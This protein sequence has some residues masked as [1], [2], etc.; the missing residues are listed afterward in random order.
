VDPVTG[1]S[2]TQQIAIGL[3][4]PLGI[5]GSTVATLVDERGDDTCPDQAYECA[6]LESGEPIVIGVIDASAPSTAWPLADLR[7]ESFP[8]IQGH[9]IQ[10]DV[11]RPGCAADAAAEDVR[12][13]ASDPPDEPPAV[14]VLAAACD[15]AAVPMAQ[16][17]SDSGISLLTLGTVS[18]VPTSPEYHLVASAPDLRAQTAGLQPVGAVSHLRE[19]LVE[20]AAGVLEDAVTAIQDVAILDEDQLLIP[21]TPLREALIAEGY[22]RAN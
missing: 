10:L 5:V 16:L 21:R 17:L 19:L 2:R 20:H 3:L 9:S 1:L 4:I 12:E 7:S 22:P 6:A 15:E 11:R 14:L 8:P 13:L 18:P